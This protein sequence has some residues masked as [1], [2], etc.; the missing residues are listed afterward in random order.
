MRNR[1]DIAYDPAVAELTLVEAAERLGMSA[2]TLRNQVRH[3]RL[4]ARLAGKTYLVTTDEVERYRQES[5]G[6]PGR[7]AKRPHEPL[8]QPHS[9]AVDGAA[10]ERLA[11][12]NG[13]RSLSIFGSTARGEA[14]PASD[15]DIV[16]DL[17]PDS[18]IGLFD[19]ARIADELSGL[20]GRQVDLVTWASLRPR[21]RAAIRREA[22]PLVAR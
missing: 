13:I 1:A 18:T 6:H 14:G 8:A 4:R 16:I 5:R 9:I 15:V 2:S 17:E 11:A 3:G 19:H 12:R 21:M 7:P 22:V 20:F 10:L